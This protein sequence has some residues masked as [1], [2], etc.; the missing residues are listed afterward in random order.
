MSLPDE[1]SAI[2]AALDHEQPPRFYRSPNGRVY[3]DRGGEL[4]PVPL[5]G[6]RA[7]AALI[8]AGKLALGPVRDDKQQLLLATAAE[9]A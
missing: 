6:A 7:F 1:E 8:D 2:L 4:M 9:P 5:H 3:R